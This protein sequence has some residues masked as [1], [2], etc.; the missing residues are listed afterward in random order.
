[1]DTSLELEGKTVV[2]RVDANHRHT[3]VFIKDDAGETQKYYFKSV[4][5]ENVEYG[6]GMIRGTFVEGWRYQIPTRLKKR[7]YFNKNH[8]PR[9]VDKYSRKILTQSK[10]VMT[11]GSSVLYED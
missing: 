2:C 10:A 3:I 1:M 4:L 8:T 9:Y 6:F 5:L 7:A 11:S